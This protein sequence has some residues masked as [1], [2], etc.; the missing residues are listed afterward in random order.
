MEDPDD[1]LFSLNDTESSKLKTKKEETSSKK[2]QIFITIAIIILLIIIISIIAIFLLTKSKD[3]NNQ[4]EIKGEIICLFN[5]KTISKE[6]NI[7]NEVYEKYSD[8]DIFID[9]KKIDYQKNY[10]F[11]SIGIHTIKFKLYNDIKLG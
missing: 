1:V 11:S 6:T 7:I 9:D 3:N 2:T 8:F 5:I 10:K 4:K